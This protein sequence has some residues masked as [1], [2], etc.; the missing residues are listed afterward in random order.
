MHKKGI[1]QDN[2]WQVADLGDIRQIIGAP[3]AA[4]LRFGIVVSRFNES[5]TRELVETA[6]QCL[7]EHGAADADITVVW[8]PG[9]FEV[10]AVIQ[11]LA[12]KREFAALIGL[13]VVIQGE[14]QHAEVINFE[15]ARAFSEISR[16]FSVPVIHEVVS[17][18]NLEQAE[19]RCTGGRNSRGWYA[20]RAAIEMAR[21]Y[22]QLKD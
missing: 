3:D 22:E 9:G 1:S 7:R 15:V 14:T 17:A 21:V 4:G 8:V 10:P 20:A 13:G 19:A 6:A 2:E 5:L 12:E 18:Y 11:K 16:K